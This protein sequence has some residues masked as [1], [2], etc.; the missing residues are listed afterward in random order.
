[1][2]TTWDLSMRSLDD[3]H[4]EMVR[5]LCSFGA[6]DIPVD[7]IVACVAALPSVNVLRRLLLGV[8]D[9]AG[10]ELPACGV[11]LHG[12]C[13]RSLV[14]WTTSTGLA[15]MHRL[16][17]VVVWES[18]PADV[19]ETVAMACMTGCSTGLDPLVSLVE[20]SGLASEAAARLRSWLPHA[21]AV[22]QKRLELC[23]TQAHLAV[24]AGLATAVASSFQLVSQFNRATRVGR[25]ALE[26]R[27]RVHGA[28]TD[29]R[30]VAAS[31][32]SLAVVLYAQG[33]VAE[34]A[35]LHRESLAMLQRLNGADADHPGVAVS[36]SNVA[37]VLY[38]QGNLAE[39]ARLHRESLAMERR[40][41]GA[42]TDHPG[43]AVSLS[44]LALVLEAQGD[45][46][47]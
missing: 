32:T 25:L 39:S 45:L 3:A 28:D 6:D 46:A 43:A 40:L 20:S 15:S 29:H 14:K 22:Q 33:D 13:E 10:A 5:L 18:S 34:S 31:L 35:R 41:H 17:Q 36:L 26:M 21:D 47:A 8:G 7:A 24:A 42:D 27:R 44:N 16:L 9:A 11:V 12:L 23:T 2:R 19:R 38:T 30:D 4:K 37:S 1:V